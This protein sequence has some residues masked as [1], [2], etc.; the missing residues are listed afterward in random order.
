LSERK[1]RSSAYKAA[2]KAA[3][4]KP[5]LIVC[6]PGGPVR[7]REAVVAHIKK[8]GLPDGFFCYSDDFAFATMRAMADLGFQPGKDAAV[9]GFDN[10][11]EADYST[12]SLSSISQPMEEL[13]RVGMHFLFNRIR[14]PKLTRQVSTIG[15][16][17]VERESSKLNP[18]K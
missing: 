1:G 18:G 14:E 12:P 8:N 15:M 5:E 11:S 2:L 13:C 6:Q 9:I 16:K 7:V 4:L 10:V 17:L 3:G